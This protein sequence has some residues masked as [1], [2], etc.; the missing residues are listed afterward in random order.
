[1]TLYNIA[2]MNCLLKLLAIVCLVELAYGWKSD[3]MKPFT[4]KCAK[5][6]VISR[7]AS[8]HSSHIQDRVYSFQCKKS[9]KNPRICGWRGYLNKFDGWIIYVC[10][11]G[12][13]ASGLHSYFSHRYKDRRWKV[14][15]C[16][17]WIRKPVDCKWSKWLNG[18]TEE[19]YDYHVPP[20]HAI[21]GI[22]CGSFWFADFK[23]GEKSRFEN[24]W[25]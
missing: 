15:C 2:I 9:S 6:G 17:S 11:N 3:L 1:M 19:Y 21:H 22:E 20:H 12:G 10:P 16:R 23:A 4:A 8:A 13:V 14:Y 18:V 25:F 7:I 24:V 5:G